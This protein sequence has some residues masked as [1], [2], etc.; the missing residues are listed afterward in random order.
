VFALQPNRP[1]EGSHSAAAAL[2][3][4]SSSEDFE[5][6]R[7]DKTGVEMLSH[8]TLQGRR[9]SADRQMLLSCTYGC[10][11]LNVFNVALLSTNLRGGFASDATSIIDDSLEALYGVLHALNYFISG[12]K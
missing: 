3:L 5:N 12:L 9:L 1:L 6:Y 4:C 7:L 2:V 11:L 8:Q 10:E